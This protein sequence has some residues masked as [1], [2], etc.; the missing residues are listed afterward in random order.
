MWNKTDI[1]IQNEGHDKKNIVQILLNNIQ[2]R[3]ISS[4]LLYLMLNYNFEK[5]LFPVVRTATKY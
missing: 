4:M 3:E 2:Q 5:V 1:P